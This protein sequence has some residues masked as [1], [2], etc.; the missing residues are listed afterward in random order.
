MEKN[1]YVV[2]SYTHYRMGKLIRSLTAGQ[3]NHVSIALDQDLSR[4][5]SFARRHY[6]TPLYGGFVKESL[7]RYHVNGK[8][9]FCMICA[10]PVSANQYAALE[11]QL[12]EMYARKD[13]YLYNFLSVLSMPFGRRVPVRD[14]CLCV[15]FVSDILS[16]LDTPVTEGQ[17]HTTSTLCTLLEPTVIYTGVMPAPTEYDEAFFLQKPVAHPAFVTIRDMFALLP[18]LSKKPAR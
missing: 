18:R 4:M 7:S 14:A 9:A 17:F 15:E 3:Y 11:M 6:R 2:F 10:I 5:Y 16:Q 13:Q 12:E 8:P 1:V